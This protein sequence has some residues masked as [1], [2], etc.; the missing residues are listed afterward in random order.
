MSQHTFEHLVLLIGT[1]PLPNFVAAEYFLQENPRLERIW[2]V[3][4]KTQRS[5]NQEGTKEFAQNL[6]SLLQTRHPHIDD[7]YVQYV[8]LSNVSRAKEIVRDVETYCLSRLGS[9]CSVHLNYTGGTKVMGTQLYRVIEQ[10]KT[11]ERIRCCS[12]SYLNA[13]TFQI[14][15]DER[16]AISGDL[17]S[18]PGISLTFG[19]M[20]ALHGFQRRN[21]PKDEHHIFQATLHAFA[22]CI[23]ENRLSDY[24]DCQHGGYKRSLFE[25]T[26]KKGELAKKIS[27]LDAERLQRYTPNETFCRILDSLPEGYRLLKDGKL[28]I[29]EFSSNKCCEQTIKFL[30]GLWLEEYAANSIQHSFPA[31]SIETNWEIAK[32]DWTTKFELDVLLVKGYQLFGISCTTSRSKKICKSKGFEILLRTRQIGGD[33]ARA[34]VVTCLAEDVRAEVEEELQVDS[35][36]GKTIIVLGMNDLKTA[37]LINHI[38]QFI[39]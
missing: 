30:D 12:F 36:S 19:E 27:R 20:I 10:A 16:D 26:K 39:K 37:T 28:T 31:L 29:T 18:E 21:T 38:Q 14:I 1:N 32:E 25:D 22:Q 33:E 35:G 3:H 15:D 8:P 2:L 6:Q 13:K 34:V 23:E 9:E 17:R 11:D 4:S 7:Q 24:F 5:I